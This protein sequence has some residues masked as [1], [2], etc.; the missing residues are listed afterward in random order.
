MS[1]RASSPPS[2]ILNA[3]ALRTDWDASIRV[4]QLNYDGPEALAGLRAELGPTHVVRRRGNRVEIAAA[5]P[6]SAIPG[7]LTC[8][9]ERV[10]PLS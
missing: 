8:P 1:L 10:H 2:L 5:D 7:E 3:I 9:H 4:G 6:T